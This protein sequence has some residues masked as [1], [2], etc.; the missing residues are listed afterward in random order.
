MRIHV[1]IGILTWCSGIFVFID[2]W[3]SRLIWQVLIGIAC[4][5]RL[6]FV[7][8]FFS[9]DFLVIGIRHVGRKYRRRSDILVVSTVGCTANLRLVNLMSDRPERVV[10]SAGVG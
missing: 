7:Y 9:W 1:A 8:H 4:D 3:N 6:P 10:A 5:Q 2:D